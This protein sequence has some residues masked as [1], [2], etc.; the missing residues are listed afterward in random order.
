ML[1]SPVAAV[2]GSVREG[3]YTSKAV[4]LLADEFA[5]SYPEVT[6]EHR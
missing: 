3:N 6:S 2:I 4:H 5:T 1:S